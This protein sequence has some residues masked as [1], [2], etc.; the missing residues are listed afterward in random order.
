MKGL[1]RSHVVLP[2]LERGAFPA[3]QGRRPQDERNLLYVALTR[4]RHA[5]T[6]LA[7]ADRPSPL[8]EEMA[9]KKPA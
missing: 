2:F 8:V 5:L 4:A 9:A 6:L 3:P 1:E 7:S